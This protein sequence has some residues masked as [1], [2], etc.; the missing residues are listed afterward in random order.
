MLCQQLLS[1]SVKN[2]NQQTGT[3]TASDLSCKHKNKNEP[4]GRP[5]AMTN[6]S[7][8]NVLENRIQ[9]INQAPPPVLHREVS[10]TKPYLIFWSISMTF[11]LVT[12]DFWYWNQTAW[13]CE[14]VFHIMFGPV[15][16][17][18]RLQSI[19]SLPCQAQEIL[20]NV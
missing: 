14:K 2:C 3:P 16:L 18:Q 20:N 17:C 1:W 6:F 11:S 5:T 15:K 7:I 19:V 10:M 13:W 12:F 8:L 9:H 4:Q